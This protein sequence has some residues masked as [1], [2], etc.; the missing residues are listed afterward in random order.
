MLR[1]LLRRLGQ[2]VVTIFIIST[3]V[4]LV[5]YF[6]PGDPVT[7]ML[8]A[9][10]TPQQEA[11]LRHQYGLDKPLPVRYGI[12]LWH[13]LHL[14]LGTSVLYGQSVISSVW[15][16]FPVTLELTL[17]SLLVALLIAVPAGILAGVRQHTW[18]DLLARSIAFLGQAIP[19]FWLG[20]MLI[21]LFSVRFPIFP[22]FGFT[23]FTDDPV[24]NLK[25]MVL[26]SFT[27]GV[28]VAAPL[29]RYLRASVIRTLGEDY[30]LTARA[31]GIR[32]RRVIARHV[33]RNSLIPFV[34]QLGL[35]FAYLLGG[36][37]VIEQV[38]SLPG[39]GQLA[40][41]AFRSRDYPVVQGVVLVIA[42]GFVLINLAVDILYSVLDP[43]I[44]LEGAQGG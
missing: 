43:R 28:Y 27:L 1:F 13:A 29:T 9:Q 37:V 30:V 42:S 19:G 2:A 14:D 24:A 40:L 39:M 25:S 22:S 38:F 33:V 32:A 11:L 31:K 5:V 17:L 20:L 4:F 34:T 3:V 8:G 15:E 7:V 18:V 16:A 35:Q 26:P 36:A 44:R 21:L 10:G 12:W 6:I 23:S 41:T